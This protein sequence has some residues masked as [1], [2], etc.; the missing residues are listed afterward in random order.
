MS[1]AQ[2]RPEEGG[3][4]KALFRMLGYAVLVIFALMAV[5]VAFT[6]MRFFLVRIPVE[7]QLACAFLVVFGVVLGVSMLR[8]ANDAIKLLTQFEA[9]FAR[10]SELTPA[11]RQSGVSR[12]KIDRL[13][14]RAARLTGSPRLWWD[15]IEEQLHPYR[16]G[17]FLLRPAREIFPEEELV[18]P[19]YHASFHQSVPGM[20]TAIG[21][22]AT[23]VAILVALLSVQYNP[24]DP[25]RPI[26]GVDGLINGLAGK[27]LSS[28]IGLLLALVFTLLERKVCERRVDAAYVKLLRHVRSVIPEL[29]LTRLLLDRTH[30]AQLLEPI[31]PIEQSDGE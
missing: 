22:M 5:A 24:N 9:V 2:L 6:T 26:T 31:E 4:V 7:I 15:S 18:E 21:L 12:E 10:L 19:H 14:E 20:L 11:E 1:V 27:F 3:A 13:R 8:Q 30:P 23:F 17:W 25:G 28:I 16:S 29:S